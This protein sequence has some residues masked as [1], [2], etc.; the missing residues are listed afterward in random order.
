[1]GKE[2]DSVMPL[3]E[4]RCKCGNQFEEVLSITDETEGTCP[5][6]GRKTREQ[7]YSLSGHVV[8]FR[9]GFDYGLGEYVK[10]ERHRQNI[11]AEN[12]LKH[13]KVG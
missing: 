2:D 13:I 4:F 1:M 3:Y 11:C 9:E 10:S 6:C 5:I 8:Y 7:K 12:N